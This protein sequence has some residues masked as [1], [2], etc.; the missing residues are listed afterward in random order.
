MGPRNRRDAKKAAKANRAYV[1]SLDWEPTYASAQAPQ[2]QVSESPVAR[3]YLESLLTGNNPDLTMRNAPNADNTKMLQQQSKD[4]MYGT[5]PEM[6]ARE[7]AE[8]QRLN[9][10]HVDQPPPL[11]NP[12][13]LRGQN[14]AMAAGRPEDVKAG[15]AIGSRIG[16]PRK[17]DQE[18]AKRTEQRQWDRLH[19]E[20]GTY[21]GLKLSQEEQ[22][23]LVGVVSDPNASNDDIDDAWRN[24]MAWQQSD[25][26]NGDNSVIS[27]KGHKIKAAAQGDYRPKR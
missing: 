23:R 12:E 7:A 19:P 27:A 3:S 10:M 26:A 9:S 5:V 13:I 21:G 8:K 24:T 1:G 17:A 16:I 18:T 14:A 25:Y 6:L 20:S 4:Q 15:I 22:A 2:M 11:E